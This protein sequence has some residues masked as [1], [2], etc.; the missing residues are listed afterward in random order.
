[1]E[2]IQLAKAPLGPSAYD[3]SP[4]PA[5]CCHSETPV[6]FLSPHHE[7]NQMP[8]GFP[9]ALAVDPLKIGSSLEPVRC[10]KLEAP[11]RRQAACGP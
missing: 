5:R 6:A 2:T 8:P 4:Y 10:W 9:S 7:Q 11:L 1:M 3:R